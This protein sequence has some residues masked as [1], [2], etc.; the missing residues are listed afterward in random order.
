[1]DKQLVDLMRIEAQGWIGTPHRNKMRKKGVGVD[2]I[3]YVCACYTAIGLH[4]DLKNYD[5][6][7]GLHKYSGQIQNAILATGLFEQVETPQDG[8]ILVFKEIKYSSHTGLFLDNKV[9]HA[10]ANRLVSAQ[11]FVHWKNEIAGIFRL[12]ESVTK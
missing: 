5:V 2:C 7:L 11:P 8:D 9:W 4:Y 6:N 3:N 10:M 1:M 12:K